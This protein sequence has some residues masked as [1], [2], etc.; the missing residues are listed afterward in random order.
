[1]LLSKDQDPEARKNEVIAHLVSYFG[2]EA[3]NYLEYAE[4]L[5]NQEKYSGGCPAVSI[6]TPNSMRDYDRALRE[7]LMN[8]HFCGS[9]TA[10]SWQGY[11]DGAV[12]SGERVANEILY[13]M[14]GD[15]DKSVPVDYEKTFYYQ[16]N[17]KPKLDILSKL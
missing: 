6:T 9:D 1:M 7:P 10:T 16:E 11:M 8:V 5:W 15:S 12:E 3:R 13:K 2:E 4:K 14:F 17:L